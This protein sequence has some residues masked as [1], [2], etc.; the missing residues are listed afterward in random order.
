MGEKN[1]VRTRDKR[2]RKNQN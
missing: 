1:R 2:E